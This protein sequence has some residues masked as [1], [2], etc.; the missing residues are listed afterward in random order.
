MQTDEQLPNV[1]DESGP[2]VPRPTLAGADYTSLEVYDAERERIWWGDWICVGRAE[3]VPNPGDY[4]TR[5]VAGESI[6]ITRNTEG[7]L[8]AFYNVCSHRGTRFVDD[9]VGHV[10][11]AFK[12]PYHA[13]TYDL[14]GLLI[15]TPNVKEDEYFDRSRF[16][17]HPVHVDSYAGFL[18]VN[19]SAEPRRTMME[20]LTQ[21][22]ETITAFERFKMDEL[23]VGVRLVYEVEANWKIIV[24]NYNECLHCPTIHPELVQ[25][26]P[27]FRFGEV[28]DEDIR[29]DGNRMMEGATSF[30]AT[31]RSSLPPLPGLAPEDHDMYYG[32]YEFPNLMLNLHPDCA[33]YYIGYPKGP[34]H[35]TV[36]SE[37]L[38]R[39]E[40]IADPAFAPEPVVEFWDTISEQ[41]W[42]V[43]ARAQTGVGSRAFTTGVYPRQD[44]FLYWFNEE[45]R[46]AMGREL[47]G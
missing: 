19:M 17:L 32:T 34:T 36:V 45:Y 46:A 14:D 21:G 13:W 1:R 42:T 25:V 40:T 33:M 26:V 5:D 7:G 30:T 15:G 2:W 47:Q 24:E 8:R 22:A 31:G 28:W 41:D 44:R 38:F 20:A 43:C 3:E 6:F 16:P 4:L 10:R 9:G 27:L 29:D 12:C 35:T 39:P 11:R 18:F 37:Y 23:R